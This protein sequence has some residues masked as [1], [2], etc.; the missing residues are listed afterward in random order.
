MI[1]LGLS[2]RNLPPRVTKVDVRSIIVDYFTEDA[3]CQTLLSTGCEKL[4]NRKSLRRRAAEKAIKQLI[5]CYEKNGMEKHPVHSRGFAFV[6]LKNHQLAL[7]LLHYL[8]NNAALFGTT[9]RPIVSFSI[10][11]KRALHHQE[12]KKKNRI[13][14]KP[15]HSFGKKKAYSRGRRQ[16]DKRRQK[17]LN[18][19]NQPTK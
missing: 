19:P 17:H 6:T 16:R 15:L 18:T 5:L 8:N 10:E 2:I 7:R 9:R 3:G 1:L 11:D 13:K 4:L 14:C 12:L